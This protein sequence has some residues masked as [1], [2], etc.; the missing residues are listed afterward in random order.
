[1]T[2]S[3][4]QPTGSQ[5]A[6]AKSI[7][8]QI[9]ARISPLANKTKRGKFFIYG[10]S[11]HGKTVL[12][13]QA[14]GAII[15]DVEKG[16]VSLFNHPDLIS[17]KD[18]K[19]LEY[20]SFYQLEEFIKLLNQGEFPEVETVVIDSMSELHKRGLAE[21]VEREW[22]NGT[23]RNSDGQKRNRYVAETEDHTENNEHIRRLTSALRDLDRNLIVTAHHR[24]VEGKSGALRA[25]Y[26][27]FSEKL[28]NTLAGIFDLVGYM[29]IKQENNQ[30]VRTL[31]CRSDGVITAKTRL[32]ALPAELVDP[33]WSDLWKAVEAQADSDTKDAVTIPSA[34]SK[35]APVGH[36]SVT[37]NSQSVPESEE[38]VSPTG[39]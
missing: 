35:Y 33:T 5:P 20:R 12:A 37:T 14:P 25:I 31:R 9:S 17:T 10:P 23:G 6:P 28:A 34:P 11:G 15:V 13:G 4:N 22:K 24:T 30:E 7:L 8:E 2:V 1:M 32:D 38:T 26:P 29:S 21:V 16:T 36:S 19:I 18:V 3:S 39:V 27:D